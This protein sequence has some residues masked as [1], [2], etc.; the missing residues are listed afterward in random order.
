MTPRFRE[1]LRRQETHVGE[2]VA[3]IESGRQLGS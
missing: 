1:L 2:S 3:A